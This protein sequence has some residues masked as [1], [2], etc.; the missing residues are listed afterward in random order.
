VHLWVVIAVQTGKEE[1]NKKQKTKLQ[2][3]FQ[4]VDLPPLTDLLG[5]IMYHMMPLV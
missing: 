5:L 1:K 2:S 4:F 3:V